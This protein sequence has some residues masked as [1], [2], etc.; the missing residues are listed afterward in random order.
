MRPLV[1]PRVGRRVWPWILCSGRGLTRTRPRR[2]GDGQEGTP[3]PV[4]M[5]TASDNPVISL[6]GLPHDA[7]K[8]ARPLDDRGVSA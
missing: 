1:H 2:G 4:P 5:P 7:D 6:W 8:I 3:A